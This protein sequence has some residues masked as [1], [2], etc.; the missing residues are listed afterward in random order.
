[1]SIK[2]KTA[3]IEHAID[4]TVLTKELGYSASETDTKDWLHYLINSSGHGVFVA[5]N[6]TCSVCGWVVVEQ[7]VSLETGYKAEISGLVVG[8]KFRRLGVG[9]KL[10]QSTEEWAV[11]NKLIKLVVSS[12][13]QRNESHSFYKSI[14]FASKKTSHKYEKFL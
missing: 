14:G 4:I 13:I 8:A 1:M 2:I 6:E 7:R 10:I 5:I 12:N 11:K 3:E 9:Q